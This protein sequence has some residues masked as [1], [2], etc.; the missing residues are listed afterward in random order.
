MLSSDVSAGFDPNYPGVFERKNAAYLGH[1]LA[2]NKYTGARGKSGCN[3]ANPEYIAHLRQIMDEAGISWQTAEL[4][5]V[6]EG[7]GGTIAGILGNLN[8]N[9]IDA[10]VPVHNMHAPWEVVSKVDVYE[11]MKG[12]M[13]FLLKA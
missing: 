3:D 12:Y 13:V 1:G 10:G 11:A 4:G 2:L 9:V 5:R 6:D 7:G 8:M